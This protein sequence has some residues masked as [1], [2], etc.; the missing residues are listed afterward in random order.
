M[1]LQGPQTWR[2]RL[3][4]LGI[5]LV[6]AG[7]A[8]HLIAAPKTPGEVI[9]I[10]GLGFLM[11]ASLRRVLSWALTLFVGKHEIIGIIIVAILITLFFKLLAAIAVSLTAGGDMA[12]FN[13]AWTNPYKTASWQG[14]L[15]WA[16]LFAIGFFLIMRPELFRYT[17]PYKDTPDSLRRALTAR[18]AAFAAASTFAY[19]FMEGYFG[20]TL[21][22]YHYF[23]HHPSV[24]AA[25]ILGVVTLLAGPYRYVAGTIWQ[26]GILKSV[27]PDAWA[28]RWVQVNHEIAKYR[29]EHKGEQASN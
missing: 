19:L 11:L 26:N 7:I 15:A 18:W 10:V 29:K 27:D 22:N 14:I 6:G 25:A 13:A 23:H 1:R 16:L 20:G 3:G 8:I 17:L 2:G 5:L 12:A 21:A 24:L 28:A 4:I 9:A